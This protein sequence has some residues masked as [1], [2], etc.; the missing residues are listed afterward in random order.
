MFA[1]ELQQAR[2]AE[3]IRRADAQRLANRA[4]AAHKAGRLLG[5]RSGRHAA[6]GQ[7]NTDPGR[8]TTAA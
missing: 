4:R 8:F 2:H 3:L 7:V 1:Y 5:R 6:E